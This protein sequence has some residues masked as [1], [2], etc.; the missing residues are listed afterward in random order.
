MN[1]PGNL[2]PCLDSIRANTK[3]SHE[4][5]VVA[6][7]FSAENL[8]KA[9][10]D[11]PEVIFIESDVLRGFSENNNLALRKATGRYCFVVNDDT[12]FNGPLIDR[13]VDD[14]SLLPETAAIISPKILNA[15][16]SLQLCGRP[17]LNATD[18]VLERFHL[19]L[20]P[21][22]DTAGKAP[23]CGDIYLTS[24]ICGAAFLIKTDV[25]RD[26][27]W[28][29]EYYFFTP[30]DYALSTL[31]RKKGYGVYVDASAEIVHKWHLTASSMA[32]ATHPAG[33]KGALC[34]FSGSSRI[35]Y[36]LVGSLTWFAQFLKWL[37]SGRGSL[38]RTVYRNEM[39]S[40]FTHLTPKE[41]FEK[42]IKH[43]GL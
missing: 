17:H 39:A 2:Y 33:M 32:V 35:K 29:D 1:R 28:F 30:E 27:G 22:D 43:A 41:L 38:S 8:E 24:N 3:I 11:Y 31:A 42:Y 4:T 16:G 23:V 14:F 37:K 10:A 18:F 40:I 7:R 12:E 9:R 6:Y 5:F 19:Y 25:F 36:L 13:L 21:K 20:P 34:F 26:L 15:D